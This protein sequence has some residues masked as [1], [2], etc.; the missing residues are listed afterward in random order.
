MTEEIKKAEKQILYYPV[1]LSHF[2]SALVKTDR[3][4]RI[5][6]TNQVKVNSSSINQSIYRKVYNQSLRLIDWFNW[7][8][9]K[10]PHG[11]DLRVGPK[12]DS[13]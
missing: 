1:M 6:Y 8:S 10:L 4:V 3:A 2:S 7:L 11:D 12:S 5:Q 13:T 9:E